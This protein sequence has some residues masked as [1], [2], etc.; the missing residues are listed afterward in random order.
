MYKISVGMALHTSAILSSVNSLWRFNFP[1]EIAQNCSIGFNQVNMEAEHQFIV[2][3]L[4]FP[5][6]W[7]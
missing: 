4:D 3:A 7:F 1:F 2:T 5:H 6:H